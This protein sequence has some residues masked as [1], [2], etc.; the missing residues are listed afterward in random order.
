VAKCNVCGA[1]VDAS[2]KACPYCGTN[3]PG[4]STLGKGGGDSASGKNIE[5]STKLFK[6]INEAGASGASEE[7][8]R[9]M[10]GFTA[11][12]SV[13]GVLLDIIKPFEPI[14]RVIGDLFGVLAG[15]AMKALLPVLKPLIKLLV[16]LMPLFEALGFIFGTVIA[17]ALKVLIMAL[18]GIAKAIAW[19]ADFFSIG[20]AGAGKAVDDFFRPIL[21]AFHTG[22]DYVPKT[23][24]YVLEEGETVEQKGGGTDNDELLFELKKINSYNKW[25]YERKMR[26]F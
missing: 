21:G 14:L 10:Q 7:L 17:F 1:P 6:E 26:E 3:R 13:F 9:T 16:K 11:M 24:P 18:Y 20:F 2:D 5:K 19:V 15:S 12:G 25:K 8:G 22:T 4:T 23:G